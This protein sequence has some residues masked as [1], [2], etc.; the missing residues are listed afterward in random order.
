MELAKNKA[1]PAKNRRNKLLTASVV[2][3]ELKMLLKMPKKPWDFCIISLED[4]LKRSR[5]SIDFYLFRLFLGPPDFNQRQERSGR[6][7][8]KYPANLQAQAVFPSLS[9]QPG[10][11]GST[12]F[13]PKDFPAGYN[14]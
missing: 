13:C 4:Y 5:C 14:R 3:K 8:L 12:L 10:A 7:L 9:D 2:R 1:R 11:I 6:N